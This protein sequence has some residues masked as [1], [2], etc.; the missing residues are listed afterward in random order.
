V[1]R[2]HRTWLATLPPEEGDDWTTEEAAEGTTDA[3]AAAAAPVDEVAPRDS[4]GRDADYVRD[5]G[6]GTTPVW[7]A[8]EPS[9]RRR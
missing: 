7:S 8:T 5:D 9:P 6:P 2:L 3:I 1:L 4:A